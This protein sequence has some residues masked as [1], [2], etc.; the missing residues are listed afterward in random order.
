MLQTCGLRMHMSIVVG[1]LEEK[2]YLAVDGRIILKC[3]SNKMGERMS[4]DNIKIDFMEMTRESMGWIH[5]TQDREN[6]TV[7]NTVMN[8]YR[9][10][11]H[12]VVYLIHTP[13]DVHIFI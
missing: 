9:C 12:F 3:V 11:V 13:T 1:K 7:L 2:H 6:W 8:L 10:T 5:V 4:E